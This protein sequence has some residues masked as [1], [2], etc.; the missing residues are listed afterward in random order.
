MHIVHVISRIFASEKCCDIKKII[1]EGTKR[2]RR[3]KTCKIFI[4]LYIH[5]N[6]LYIIFRGAIIIFED[7]KVTS[8]KPFI[9]AV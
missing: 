4:L 2:K 5:Y 8:N 9:R 1:T 6:Y 3:R 7:N